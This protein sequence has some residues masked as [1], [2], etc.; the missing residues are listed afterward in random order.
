MK[1]SYLK[2]ISLAIIVTVFAFGPLSIQFVGAQ[3]NSNEATAV[4]TTYTPLA[5]LPNLETLQLE[6]TVNFRGYVTYAFNLLIAIG[7]VAAVFMITWGGFEYMT[8][9]AVQGKSEGLAKIQN[10]IYG[11]LLIL[12][13]YLI[14]RTID[15]RFV[16]IPDT[17]VP[18][19]Q[20]CTSTIKTNCLNT[21]RNTAFIDSLKLTLLKFQNDINGSLNIIN[22]ADQKIIEAQKQQDLAAQ[23]IQDLSGNNPDVACIGVT[24]ENDPELNA[25]CNKYYI[26]IDTI[27]QQKGIASSATA[28]G[29]FAN[30]MKE[31][32]N[33][34]TNATYSQNMSY[35]QDNKKKIDA[36]YA[37]QVKTLADLGNPVDE[38]GVA[39]K[40]QLDDSY[41]LTL[42]KLDIQTAL[43]TY[44]DKKGLSPASSNA[45]WSAAAETLSDIGW[46][47]GKATDYATL[48]GASYAYQT[49]KDYTNGGAGIDKIGIDTNKTMF[50]TYDRYKNK[51]SDDSKL[52]LLKTIQ[53]LSIQS[54]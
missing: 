5:P 36:V 2:N 46:I 14:L 20:S 43:I 35:V 26:S 53:T 34:L 17:L 54:K 16:S 31:N 12:T 10:A 47:V 1:F 42:A 50:D 48:T 25:A 38:K 7:A 3:E 13:S 4:P 40:T 9:D 49:I 32:I 30:L 11:L 18:P 27:N 29:T 19:I 51:L 6:K 52:N 45:L 41:N 39:L 15:P 8:T 22:T 24:N 23:L 44:A 28:V 37:A 33:G 21:D